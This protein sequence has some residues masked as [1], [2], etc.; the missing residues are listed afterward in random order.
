[1]GGPAVHVADEAPE[2]NHKLEVFHVLVSEIDG[3]TVIKHEDNARHRQDEKEKKGKAA[4]SPAVGVFNAALAE[5]GRMEVE[6][7]VSENVL[8][9]VARGVFP[10]PAPE[11][12]APNLAVD[13][14]VGDFFK[15][16][17][18]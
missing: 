13:D 16:G 6:P 17:P 1:M 3:G 2:R 5:A 15:I 8:G 4:Q 14:L 10:G 7:D 11:H 9:A 18:R 12:R